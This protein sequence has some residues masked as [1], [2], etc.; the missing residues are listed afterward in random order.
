MSDA[1]SVRGSDAVKTALIEAA[2]D[3]LGEV[4]PRALSIRN[5]AERAGV[6]HGQI[7]HY[8]GG[9]RGLLRA[10]MA[11]LAAEHWENALARSGGDPVPPPLSLEEDARYWQAICR[12]VIEGDLD[13]ARVAMDE[14]VSVPQR[15]FSMIRDKNQIGE[16]DL[17]AKAKFAY[18]VVGQ[19]GWVAFE[20][21]LM[22]LVG[23]E[24]GDRHE[25]RE[26][27]KQLSNEM[28]KGFFGDTT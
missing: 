20:E 22:R 6:N 9:K 26:H 12:S 27:V 14:G 11:S 17:E 2:C 13:L 8:F 24:E 21:Y 3:M 4:G 15:A 19:L 10:A 25:F 1:S 16:D 5:V 18:L 23:V 7:H 28:V